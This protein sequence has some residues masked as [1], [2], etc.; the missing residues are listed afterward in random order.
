MSNYQLSVK[1]YPSYKD[2]GVEWLGDVPDHWEVKRIKELTTTISKGTT[3]STEGFTFVDEG[4]RFIKAENI[5][6]TKIIS[7]FPA[8]YITED[9]NET[10]S[11]SKLKLRDILIVIVGAT[12]GKIGIVDEDLLPSNTNQAVC[13]IRFKKIKNID[14][15]YYIFVSD[16]FLKYVWYSIV[17]S[18]QPNLSMGVLGNFLLFI[19][20]TTEQKLIAHYLYTKTSQIDRKIDLLTQKATQYGSLKQ[21]LINETVTRGLDKSVSMKDSAIEWIGEVPKHWGVM[22]IKEVA[23]INKRTL[24]EKTPKDYEFDY[25]D[26]GSITYGVK[27]FSSEHMTFEN[28]TSRAKRIVKRGDT[29]IST[30]RTYLKTITSIDDDVSDLMV[31]TGFAVISP[32][33]ALFS[34]YFSYLSISSFIVE[35]ICALSTGVSYPATNSSSIVDLLCL[36]PPLSEQKAI[37]DYLDTKTAQIDQI[38]QTLNTQIEK[39]KELR[40]TL[41]N[42]VVTG[43][44]RVTEN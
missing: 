19:P 23:F 37:A 1:S 30:V 33:R 22:R 10:L 28:A 12:I 11:R 17:Q 14:F 8:F 20:N 13:F 21:S 16:Y 34:K 29:I 4:V 32:R 40:K 31:S 6:N 43:K 39:L 42:D 25:I 27:G 2:I 7:R 41:I 9:A 38:I 35:K 3:P 15:L 18:A 24:T 44:I 36:I 5:N 26:I